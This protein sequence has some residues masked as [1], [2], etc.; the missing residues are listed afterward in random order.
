MQKLQEINDDFRPA[1]S[2][3]EEWGYEV[4]EN[5]HIGYKMHHQEKVQILNK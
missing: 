3:L 1:K 4:L 5:G 2:Y